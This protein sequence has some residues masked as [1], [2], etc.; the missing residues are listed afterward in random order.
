MPP[1]TQA[2]I[3]ENLEW[4][5]PVSITPKVQAIYPTVTSKQVHKA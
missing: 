4:S 2:I 1:G 3:H 5:T